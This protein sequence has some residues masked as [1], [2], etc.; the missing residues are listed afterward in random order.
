MK[1]QIWCAVS[2]YVLIAIV[3]A[4]LKLPHSLY[5]VLQILSIS[6]FEKTP[7]LQ[8]FGRISDLIEM[9]INSNQLNLLGF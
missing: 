9:E 6:V 7:L 4:E 3:R 2:T 8:A 1:S 5:T